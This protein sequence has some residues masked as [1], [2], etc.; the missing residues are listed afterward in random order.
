[1]A[2]TKVD[3]TSD[4]ARTDDNA[5]ETRAELKEKAAAGVKKAIGNKPDDKVR[6]QET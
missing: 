4:A 3:P 2:N 5:D 6:R 1:M